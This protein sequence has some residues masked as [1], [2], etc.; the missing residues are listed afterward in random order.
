MTL[1]DTKLISLDGLARA[2]KAKIPYVLTK[3]SVHGR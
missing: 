3:Q 2:G 1:G